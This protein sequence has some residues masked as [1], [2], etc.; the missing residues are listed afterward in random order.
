MVRVV[1]MVC[2]FMKIKNCPK[3]SLL[4]YFD[5]KERNIKANN[6]LKNKLLP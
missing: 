2:A 4:K 3:V 5:N 6:L 1:R